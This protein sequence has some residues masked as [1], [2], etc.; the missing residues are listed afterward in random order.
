MTDV[1]MPPDGRYEGI[2]N[3]LLL[4]LRNEATAAGVVSGDLFLIVPGRPA[5]LASFRTGPDAPVPGSAGPWRMRCQDSEGRVSAGDLELRPLPDGGLAVRLRLDRQLN[6]LPAVDPID[7]RVG[8]AGQ[9]FRI[10]GVEVEREEGVEIPAGALAT[11]RSCL[12]GAGVEVRFRDGGPLIPRQAGGWEW[13]EGNIYGALDRAMARF[14]NPAPTGPDWQAQLLML[15]HPFEQRN[16]LFGVMFDIVDQPRQGC[17]VFV[18]EIR[19]HFHDHREDRDI[20]WTMA[21]EVGHTLNLAHRFELDVGRADSTSV[22]NYA[23]EYRGGALQAEYWQRFAFRFDPDELSFVRHG[24]RRA[25]RPGASPFRAF[26]YWSTAAGAQPAHV[27]SEPGR[28]LVLSLVPPRGGTLF[29]FG[30]PVVLQVL[31]SNAGDAEV[32]LPRNVLDVKAGFLQIMVER[33]PAPGPARLADA[34]AFAPMMQRCFTDVTPGPQRLLPGAAPLSRN[35]NLTFGGAGHPLAEPGRYRLT[36]VLTVPDGAGRGFLTVTR[37]ESLRVRIGAP[38]DRHDER[39]AV[40]LLQPGVGAFFAVGG[41]NRFGTVPGDLRDIAADRLGRHGSADP[42]AA[43]IH[44]TLGIYYSR[45]HLEFG[46]DG[47]VVGRAEQ[48]EAVLLLNRLTGNKE[49]MDTFDPQTV[50][51][52]EELA[53]RVR[54]MRG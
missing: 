16:G 32:L 3:D 8:P 51:D 10:L 50:K 52:V 11:L 44:R 42:I 23:D 28:G 18:D 13:H 30:Q 29:A 43:A 22:M 33:D 6:A 45:A 38:V 49:A 24:S 14:R 4:E 34:Q 1:T 26:D 5:H 39:D 12:A 27:P 40:A 35:V 17:A 2:D 15:S 9:A 21:H 19:E 25:V 46:T 37:G 47:C 20:A 54:R 41:T 7:V 31:L 53:G 48:D 36:P